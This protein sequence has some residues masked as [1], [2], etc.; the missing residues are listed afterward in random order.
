MEDEKEEVQEEVKN[1]MR[2]FIASD[3]A[4]R[5]PNSDSGIVLSFAKFVL[6]IGLIAGAIYGVYKWHPWKEIAETKDGP[7]V[8]NCGYGYETTRAI[9]ILGFRFNEEKSVV[10]TEDIIV[11]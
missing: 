3:N 10:C 11:E 9:E 2:R 4:L 8:G 1:R 7:N 5:R 6:V